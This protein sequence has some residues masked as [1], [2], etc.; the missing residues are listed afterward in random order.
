MVQLCELS[1]H[2]TIDW[3][4]CLSCCG[5]TQPL[6]FPPGGIPFPLV[7]EIKMNYVCI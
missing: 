4:Q 5:D 7:P 6:S 1:L 2:C 3:L